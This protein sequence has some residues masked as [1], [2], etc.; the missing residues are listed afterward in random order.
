MIQVKFNFKYKNYQEGILSNILQN[1][2]N[3]INA[4]CRQFINSY[5]GKQIFNE[6]VAPQAKCEPSLKLI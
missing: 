6:I 1:M 5:Q 3:F 4:Y 2:S